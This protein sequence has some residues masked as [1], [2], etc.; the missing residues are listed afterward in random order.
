MDP[1][2]YHDLGAAD[3]PQLRLEA[4]L[5]ACDLFRRSGLAL[6]STR[7]NRHVHPE[8]ASDCLDYAAIEVMGSG[9]FERRRGRERMLADVGTLVLFN[10]GESFEIRHPI[11]DANEGTTIRI[12]ARAWDAMCAARRRATGA[13][14]GFAHAAL[15]CPASLVFALNVLAAHAADLDPLDCEERVLQLVLDAVA[16]DVADDDREPASEAARRTARV[17]LEVLN[18]SF[19]RPIH[20]DEVAREA[21]RS[22]WHVAKQFRQATGSTVHA[23]LVRIRLRHAL[24]ALARGA[25]DLTTVALDVGF[26]SHSHFTSAFRREFGLS[27]GRARDLLAPELHRDRR[28]H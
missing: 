27:P 26:G 3:A 7:W 24:R 14:N 4:R 25:P 19:A 28:T 10:P 12:D 20:L 2:R 1:G 13:R 8:R 5:A 15:P 22:V 23:R 18:E 11:G 21:G 6:L 16:L 9:T 17:V